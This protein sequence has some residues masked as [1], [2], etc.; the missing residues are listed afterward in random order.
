MNREH[1]Q[2]RKIPRRLD[3]EQIE[4]DRRD[5]I[6]PYKPSLA[7]SSNSYDCLSF[8]PLLIA[9]D[10]RTIIDQLGSQA[11]WIGH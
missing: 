6:K 2:V 1:A 7:N 4:L 9:P 5:R 8:F 10:M 3:T 11:D